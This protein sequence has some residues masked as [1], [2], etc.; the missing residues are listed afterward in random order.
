MVMENLGENTAE[1]IYNLY[2]VVPLRPP[3]LRQPEKAYCERCRRRRPMTVDEIRL[4]GS[5]FEE[6][7][8]R[9]GVL[10]VPNLD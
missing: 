8:R 10:E 7:T 9:F 6:N 5:A 2:D 4:G 1:F 3:S